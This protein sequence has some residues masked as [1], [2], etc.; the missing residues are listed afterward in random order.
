LHPEQDAQQ[1][2]EG[3]HD[4]FAAFTT[5]ARLNAI[6]AINTIALMFF[7]DFSPLK[8]QIGFCGPM[9]SHQRNQG[10]VHV[11]ISKCGAGAFLGEYLYRCARQEDQSRPNNRTKLSPNRKDWKPERSVVEEQPPAWQRSTSRRQ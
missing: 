11:V 2:A 5:P 6:T 8:N 4:S 1:S 9:A 10:R 3:Q 7:M